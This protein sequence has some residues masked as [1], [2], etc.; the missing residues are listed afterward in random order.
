MLDPDGVQ[1]KAEFPELSL[2]RMPFPRSQSSMAV[3]YLTT[4][5]SFM[6]VYIVLVPLLH[7]AKNIVLEKEAGIKVGQ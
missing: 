1:A 2:R 5:G 3:L 7:V 6:W 4:I